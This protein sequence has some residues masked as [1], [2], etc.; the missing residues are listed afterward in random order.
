MN[1]VDVADITFPEP[2]TARF[3]RVIPKSWNFWV[4]MRLEVIVCDNTGKVKLGNNILHVL[5]IN[6]KTACPVEI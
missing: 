1:A 4:A 2:I 6:S 5:I 3:L